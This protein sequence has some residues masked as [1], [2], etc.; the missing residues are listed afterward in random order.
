MTDLFRLTALAAA[1][2]VLLG[3]QPAAAGPDAVA[4]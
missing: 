3:P 1:V 2:A 4:R